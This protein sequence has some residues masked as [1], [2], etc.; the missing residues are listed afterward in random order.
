MEARSYQ[1]THEKL[2]KQ[3]KMIWEGFLTK[4]TTYGE[5]NEPILAALVDELI[6]T[7]LTRSQKN[8]IDCVRC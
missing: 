1:A 2:T 8:K 6:P 4:K 3:E 7:F 5:R